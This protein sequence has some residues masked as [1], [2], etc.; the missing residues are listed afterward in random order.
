MAVHFHPLRI[1]N[2]KRETPDCVSIALEVPQPLDA[3]FRFMEGQNITVRSTIGGEEIRRSY[4]ICN[5][6]HE[7]ELK[8]A[9][10]KIAGGLFSGFANE[11][12]K[13]GDLVEVLPP[14]GKFNAR[15]SNNQNGN[16]LAVAAGSGITPIISIIKHSLQKQPDSQF[17]LIYCNR[18][19]N[20]IIFFEELEGLKNKYMERFSLINLLSREKIEPAIFYGRINKEKLA[21]LEKIV[22]FS[23]FNEIYLCGPEEMIFT[24]SDYFQQIGIKKENIHFELFTTP[25]QKQSSGQIQQSQHDSGPKSDITVKLDGRSI[26]FKLGT[27]SLSILDAALQQGADLPFACKGGVCATCRAKLLAGK[28][29]MDVNYALEKEEIEQGFILT[30]QSHPVTEKVVVDFDVK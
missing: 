22:P 24:A 20:S 6:P 25:G 27:N 19:R 5:A 26:D 2:I 8:I 13:P 29:K 11:A 23:T 18:D 4:S 1:K 12:L 21:G 10:K 17:T 15:L 9:V 16:Y 7:N 14:T 30:C 28:V 3:T